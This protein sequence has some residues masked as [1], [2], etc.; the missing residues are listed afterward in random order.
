MKAGI[1]KKIVEHH[2][3]EKL[4]LN[5]KPLQLPF[6]A[7]ECINFQLKDRDI[8]LVIKSEKDMKLVLQFLIIK[9]KSY[10]GKPGSVLKIKNQPSY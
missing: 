9:L 4:K 10:N 8:D 6:Y 1:S 3:E 5:S 7:W 2:L